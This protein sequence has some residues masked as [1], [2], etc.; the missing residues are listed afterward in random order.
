L[1]AFANKRV[2][3]AAREVISRPEIPFFAHDTS[4]VEVP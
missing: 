3:L 1:S 2:L 4:L